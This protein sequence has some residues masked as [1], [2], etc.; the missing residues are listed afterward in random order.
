[1]RKF[2]LAA[3]AMAFGLLLLS[4][5]GVI[6]Q[7]GTYQNGVYRAEFEGYDSYGYRDFIEVTVQD[8]T[9][10]AIVYN[11]VN[12]EGTL[13]TEDEKYATDMQAAVHDTYPQKYTSDLINQM[14]EKQDIE[15]VDILAGAT[16]SSQSF[17]T[18]FNALRQ[19]ML[20]GNEET[21]VVAN[22]APQK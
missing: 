9:V 13:K 15:K 22:I 1:M 12:E 16:Y 18:L 19:N 7:S 5:C 10:T 20:A 3:M 8:G 6:S 4:S 11:G 2:T 17:K 14:L 21:V